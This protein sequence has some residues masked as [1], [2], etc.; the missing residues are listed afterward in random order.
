MK[1][2]FV[3]PAVLYYDEDNLNYELIRNYEIKNWR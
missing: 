1:Q 3:F 2:Q